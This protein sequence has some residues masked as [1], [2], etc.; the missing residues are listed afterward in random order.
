MAT[1]NNG[2]PKDPPLQTV[3]AGGKSTR[4][5]IGAA[6][7][8]LE[9][10]ARQFH[11]RVEPLVT[12]NGYRSSALNDA[13]GGIKTSNHLS[14]TA[15]DLNG[16][17]HPYEATASP[18]NK[19]QNYKSGFTA[20]QTAEIRRILSEAQGAIR[21]GQDFAYGYRDAMHFEIRGGVQ[22]VNNVLDSVSRPNIPTPKPLPIPDLE[23][24]ELPKENEMWLLKDA[25]GRIWYVTGTAYAPAVDQNELV[26]V[27]KMLEKE[28]NTEVK[29]DEFEKTRIFQ[30]IDRLRA[31]S[32]W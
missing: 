18:A 16:Y 1:S 23:P 22:T 25:A 3:T 13:S 9:W 24:V 4:L 20:A 6:G 29:V 30:A 8:L 11:A 5:V 32:K 14:G 10:F 2:W 19:Y 12:F 28:P 21:W 26:A 7:N 31:A 27:L 17:R 15:I